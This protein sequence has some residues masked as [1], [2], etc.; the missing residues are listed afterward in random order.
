VRHQPRS[1]FN[2]PTQFSSWPKQRDG[3][4]VV[5][6]RQGERGLAWR[7][8]GLLPTMIPM[9]TSVMT[10]SYSSRVAAQY[11]P[12]GCTESRTRAYEAASCCVKQLNQEMR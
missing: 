11:D 12:R 9:F 2:A 3:G 10:A 1:G 4:G 6:R 7:P 8:G 5:P